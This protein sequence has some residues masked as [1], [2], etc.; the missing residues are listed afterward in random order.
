MGEKIVGDWIGK[1]L[2]LSGFA[3]LGGAFIQIIAAVH[4]I[5]GFMN[6]I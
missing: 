5:A 3:F 2:G 1:V 4:V 6:L